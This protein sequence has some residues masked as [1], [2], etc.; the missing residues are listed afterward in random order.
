[1]CIYYLLY[2]Y[3]CITVP[4]S[5]ASVCGRVCGKLKHVINRIV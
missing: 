4:V 1:M 5:T 2:M 3:I